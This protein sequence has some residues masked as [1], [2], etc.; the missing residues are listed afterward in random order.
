MSRCSIRLLQVVVLLVVALIGPRLTIGQE[1]TTSD[2][3]AYRGPRFEAGSRGDLAIRSA[4]TTPEA[5]AWHVVP[6]G[7]LLPQN[8]DLRTSA[9]GTCWLSLDEATVQLAAEATGRLAGSKVELRSGTLI[10]VTR[11]RTESANGSVQIGA[12]RIEPSTDA[13]VECEIAG[14]S[15]IVRVAHGSVALRG[16]DEPLATLNAPQFVTWRLADTKPMFADAAKAPQLTPEAVKRIEEASV[17]P[18]AQGVGQLLVQDS[19]ADSPVRLNLA[20]Y[21]VN[22]VLQ[23]PVAL[24]QIDQSFFNP[25]H[26]QQEGTFLFNLPEGSSVSRFAMFTTPTTLIEGELIERKQ[27]AGI[28]QSI[29]NARRDPAILEQLGSNLFRM[30]VFPIFA[31]DTKRIL[32]DYTLP[33][34]EQPDGGYSFQLPLMSDLEPIWDFRIR[35]TIRGRTIE[36]SALSASHPEVPFVKHGEDSIRFELRKHGYKPQGSLLVRFKQPPTTEVV[37]RSHTSPE[38]EGADGAKTPGASYFLATLPAELLTKAKTVPVAGAEGA[39]GQAFGE[40]AKE[41]ALPLDVLI[42]ADTSAR[43]RERDRMVGAVRTILHT[44][45]AGDRYQLGC[46]DVGYRPL[47]SGWQALEEATTAA[48]LK[49]LSEQVML[50]GTD[51][52]HSVTAALDSLPVPE[53]GRR[54]LMIYVGDGQLPRNEVGLD[55]EWLLHAADVEKFIQP[56][57]KQAQVRACAVLF[58]DDDR[59]RGLFQRLA[60]SS[61][62]RVFV[63]PGQRSF[64]SFYEWLL[65]HCPSPLQNVRLSAKGIPSQDLFLRENWLP[66]EP[67]QIYGK[68]A[69]TGDL[70]LTV[71]FERDGTKYE[72]TQTVHVDADRQDMFVGRLW[73]QYKLDQLRLGLVSRTD[74]EGAWVTASDE[75][76]AVSQEWT[77]LSPATAFLVLETEAEYARYNI[78]RRRRQK[79]WRPGDYVAVPVPAELLRTSPSVNKQGFGPARREIIAAPEFNEL[80]E[81]AR[82]NIEQRE[83][84][85]ALRLLGSVAYTDLAAVS[86]EFAKLLE[87][88]KVVVFRQEFTRSMGA[89]RPLF[90]RSG[91]IDFAAG[92]SV[93]PADQLERWLAVSN[94]RGQVDM[95]PAEQAMLKV[96]TPPEGQLTLEQWMHWIGK[97]SGHN[98]VI[99]SEVLEDDGVDLSTPLEQKGIHSMSLKS[100]GIHL[101]RQVQTTWYF[102]DGV[103]NFST[104]LKAGEKLET[105]LY[106]VVDLVHASV[107]TQPWQLA[108]LDLD[109]RIAAANRLERRLD[110]RMSLDVSDAPLRDVLAIIEAK[111]QDNFVIDRKPIEDDGIDLKRRLTLKL[112]N[113]PI[114]VVLKQVCGPRG[115][116]TTI[117]DEALVVTATLKA[118]EVLE[119]RVHSGIGLLFLGYPTLESRHARG[120]DGGFGGGGGGFGEFGSAGFGGGFGGG[121]F[122]GAGGSLGGGAGGGGGSPGAATPGI[123]ITGDDN[124]APATPAAPVA[125]TVPPTAPAGSPPAAE[126]PPDVI[127]SP[128]QIWGGGSGTDIESLVD[129]ITST[130]DPEAWDEV[131]GAG[132]IRPMRDLVSFSIRA[133]RDQHSQVE[134]LFDKLRAVPPVQSQVGAPA[135]VRVVGFGD[136]DE[137]TELLQATVEPESWDEV[138]GP[139][140]IRVDTQRAMLVIRQTSALHTEIRETLTQLRRAKVEGLAGRVW[141]A[142]DVYDPRRAFGQAGLTELPIRPQAERPLP[143]PIELLAL[144]ARRQPFSGR[145]SWRRTRQPEAP[146]ITTLRTAGNRFEVELDGRVARVDGDEAAVAY[147]GLKFV[148][149]GTWGEALREVIDTRLPWLPH[150]SNEDLAREFEIS[151]ADKPI[152]EVPANDAVTLRLG[153]PGAPAEVFLEIAFSKANGLPVKWEAWMHGELWLGLKFEN[154][155]EING[156]PLWQTVIA[157]NADGKILER[158]ELVAQPA[159]PAPVVEA[160]LAPLAEWPAYL[161]WDDRL[162]GRILQAPLGRA[163]DA[164][165]NAEWALAQTNFDAALVQFPDHPLLQYLK[166]WTLKLE[167]SDLRSRR[168]PGVVNPQENAP[169]VDLAALDQAMHEKIV[170]LLTPVVSQA[171]AELAQGVNTRTFPDLG[172]QALHALL[173]L[174]PEATRGVRDWEQLAETSRQEL[175]LERAVNEMLKAMELAGQATDTGSLTAFERERLLETWLIELQ[176]LPEALTRINAFATRPTTSPEQIATLAELL[177]AYRQTKE[178]RR[179]LDLALAHP[180]ATGVRRAPLLKILAT[181][182]TGPARWRALLEA[183]ALLRLHSGNRQE[184]LDE[185]IRELDVSQVKLVGTLADETQDRPLRTALLRHQ[186]ALYDKSLDFK[187][188]ADI[189]WRLHTEGL[190]PADFHWLCQHLSRADQS[191][192]LISLLEARLQTTWPLHAIEY[193]WLATAYNN[194]GRLADAH[195]ARTSVSD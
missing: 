62:G 111:I 69:K 125:E 54:R 158:W 137:L 45:R 50:G 152:G 126:T 193:D 105:R 57:L 138:G 146:Q 19:Q 151:F 25:Y 24:V 78:V 183:T 134:R 174:R 89:M 16:G 170:A 107:P 186:I 159:Q 71:A 188:A 124:P 66:G 121:G 119:T 6:H 169:V 104:A 118:G 60:T 165:R 130:I 191:D 153:A 30:R 87:Q 38:I 163:L 155:G 120:F 98:Y 102:E 136:P 39:A 47:S 103:L 27:A 75:I 70:P 142:T 10:L 41:A 35:G 132:S 161:P 17:Q 100:L 86:S 101:L 33:L 171:P 63:L 181:G 184:T 51:L 43:F 135:R 81:K 37:V 34:E 15:A 173:S 13:I 176:R 22:V 179:F 52:S 122:G 31:R 14:E 83:G 192:R 93:R 149:F 143:Q 157:E 129:I 131:G 147:P 109:N 82:K 84:E 76:V 190:P 127:Q 106:P 20:H 145:Q 40:T 56:A 96:V 128:Q 175:N 108:D 114:R 32:L 64:G 88:A 167:Q 29:V 168:L 58:E 189:A 36:G 61:G 42:L 8:A 113:L 117:Q 44:L 49:V 133:T 94:A 28:Y 180:S 166:A 148:E 53:P 12:V 18:Q 59:G 77:L 1:Q 182:Q 5:E 46:V 99:H 74:P 65:T 141:K 91:T 194:T 139:S 95:D 187:A 48:S 162:R 178:A 3:V 116:T 21:H 85:E 150:R 11:K 110:Q 185:L 2:P 144:R 177:N 112:D 9:A 154:L 23:P 172:P 160:T 90:D 7:E 195:R 123:A 115:L 164:A 68:S 92:M 79:Y 140:S 55:F 4:G 80:L 67:L 156:E 26:R 97:E 73:G 72:L